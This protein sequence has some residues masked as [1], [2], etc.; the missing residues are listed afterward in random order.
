MKFLYTFE[1]SYAYKQHSTNLIVKEFFD[2]KGESVKEGK[3]EFYVQESTNTLYYFVGEYDIE[4]FPL[5]Y[6]EG[7][8][9]EI[10]HQIY[11]PLIK[12]LTRLTE[13]EIEEEIRRYPKKRSWIEKMLKE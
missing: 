8:S 10:K 3:A 5:F 7:V 1:Y 2:K 11:E 9:K 4:G 12:T 6:I 13:K